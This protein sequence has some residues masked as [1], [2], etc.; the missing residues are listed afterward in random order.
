MKIIVISKHWLALP[1]RSLS[2]RAPTDEVNDWC[3][4][5]HRFIDYWLNL[6]F[7][8]HPSLLSFFALRLPQVPSIGEP[9]GCHR[10]AMHLPPTKEIQTAAESDAG[11]FCWAFLWSSPSCGEETKGQRQ[12]SSSSFLWSLFLWEI[13]S[14]ETTERPWKIRRRD[15]TLD[16]EDANLF[17]LGLLSDRSELQKGMMHQIHALTQWNRKSESKHWKDLECIIK[18]WNGCYQP[19]LSLSFCSAV[20]SMQIALSVSLTALPFDGC[21]IIGLFL[22]PAFPWEAARKRI[23]WYLLWIHSQLQSTS[24]GWTIIGIEEFSTRMRMIPS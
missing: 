16:L 17:N 11:L 19:S 22:E 2:R 21:I 12:R 10:R 18:D 6:E 1:F 24:D 15:T 23:Q 9:A 13:E 5:I 20:L 8:C 4:Q 14:Q 7:C 3:Q